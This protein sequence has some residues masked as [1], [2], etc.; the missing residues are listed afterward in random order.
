MISPELSESN[1]ADLS[2]GRRCE[3]SF[4]GTGHTVAIAAPSDGPPTSLGVGV[5]VAGANPNR[6]PCSSRYPP[7]RSLLLVNGIF[8]LSLSLSFSVPLFLFC[9]RVLRSRSR[10]FLPGV[11]SSR[12]IIDA[13][14][15]YIKSPPVGL[16]FLAAAT[17]R[18]FDLP[19]SRWA[20]VDEPA[21]RIAKQPSRHFILHEVEW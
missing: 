16:I 12:R 7:S 17:R 20:E 15:R 10:S 14:R 5:G 2:R 18:S 13:R 8:F 3:T 9:H 4:T 1:S 21:N 19:D 6:I 11:S